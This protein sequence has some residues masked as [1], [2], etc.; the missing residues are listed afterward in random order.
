M[1][2]AETLRDLLARR[3]FIAT[4]ILASGKLIYI[5]KDSL[6]DCG[7]TSTYIVINEAIIPE[8]YKKLGI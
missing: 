7:C 4:S 3:T 8:I 5:L 1:Y 2:L 6:V